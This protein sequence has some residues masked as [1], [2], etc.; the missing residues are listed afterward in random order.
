MTTNHLERLDPALTRPGRCDLHLH[1]GLASRAQVTTMYRRFYPE[2][3]EDDVIVSQQSALNNCLPPLRRDRS[4]YF[5]FLSAIIRLAVHP[6]TLFY[7]VLVDEE[8][9]TTSSSAR[10]ETPPGEQ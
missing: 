2:A 7:E 9:S 5:S 6:F 8:G 10:M 3:P 4:F 1:L